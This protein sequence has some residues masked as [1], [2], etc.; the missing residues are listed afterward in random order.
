MTSAAMLLHPLALCVRLHTACIDSRLLLIV[1]VIDS[2]QLMRVCEHT[3]ARVCTVS[4]N[5]A[6][7]SCAHCT[8]TVTSAAYSFCYQTLQSN[9][10]LSIQKKCCSTDTARKTCKL[11]LWRLQHHDSTTASSRIDATLNVM[12]TLHALL[13]QLFL[14]DCA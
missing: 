11:A 7:S 12:P 10:R 13:L 9:T 14:A 3:S 6:T 4:S 2:T 5:N 8:D 1:G